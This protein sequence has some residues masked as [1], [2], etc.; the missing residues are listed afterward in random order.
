[1]T[2]KKKF[3]YCSI[4][5]LATLLIACEENETMP[6]YKKLGTATHTMAGISVSNAAPLPSEN[7]SVLISYVNPSSDPLKEISVQAKVGAGEFVEIKKFDV[8][9]D[10]MDELMTDVFLFPAPASA[11][12]TV[13]FDM[14]ITSQ[15]EYPQVK[16]TSFKT[17]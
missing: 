15:K 16:R 11:A 5:A 17:K 9:S 7:V 3:L 1:M 14:V 4:I 2:M 12:T 8:S 6:S 10:P 13:V